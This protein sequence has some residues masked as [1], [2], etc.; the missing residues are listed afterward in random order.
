MYD[1]GR[2]NSF[3]I[4]WLFSVTVTFQLVFPGTAHNVPGN[5]PVTGNAGLDTHLFKRNML[6]EICEDH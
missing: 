3:E 4:L 1:A 5:A 6:A 2:L